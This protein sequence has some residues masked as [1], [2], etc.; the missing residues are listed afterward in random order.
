MT[1]TT[2]ETTMT[3]TYEVREPTPNGYEVV[4]RH[5]TRAAAERAVERYARRHGL[6]DDGAGCGD[7]GWPAI[8][9]VRS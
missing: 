4:S 8:V 5:R 3:T 1:T 6:V 9:E 7:D 2:E